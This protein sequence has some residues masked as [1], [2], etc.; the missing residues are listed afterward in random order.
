MID[1]VGFTD[2]I[3]VEKVDSYLSNASFPTGGAL[4]VS[5]TDMSGS[6]RLFIFTLFSML[7]MSVGTWAHVC[8]YMCA[9]RSQRTD[10]GRDSF[11]M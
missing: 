2:V 9:C 3:L 11:I 10:C 8:H 1:P 6:N 7:C 5:L 4:C